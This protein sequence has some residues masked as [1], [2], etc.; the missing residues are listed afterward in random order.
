VNGGTVGFC[1]QFTLEAEAGEDCV[2]CC[3][4]VVAAFG[5]EGSDVLQVLEV[6]YSPWLGGVLCLPQEGDHRV[7]TRLRPG[8]GTAPSACR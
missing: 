5:Q 6:G 4:D 8:R 2:L 3:G 1:R 7:S